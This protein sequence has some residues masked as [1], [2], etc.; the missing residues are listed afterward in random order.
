MA[1]SASTSALPRPVPPRSALTRPVLNGT[2]AAVTA[3]LLLT[4]TAG[5]LLLLPDAT[6]DA[7]PAA[8]PAALC[9]PIAP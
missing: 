9:T 8:L 7:R 1:T 3:S 5:A 4:L 2:R 6:G